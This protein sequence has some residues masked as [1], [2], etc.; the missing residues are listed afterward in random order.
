MKKAAAALVVLGIVLVLLEGLSW[1]ALRLRPTGNPLALPAAEAALHFYQPSDGWL[2]YR[3]KPNH[4]QRFRSDE[5]DTDIR[6]NSFGFRE[7]AE[8][9]GPVDI[10]VV[11]DTFA[12]GHGVE[13]GER[14]SDLLR[15]ARA[16]G[17]VWSF[18]LANGYAPPHYL[19][20]LRNNLQF[21]PQRLVIELFPWND[22][23]LNMF[24]MAFERDSN[25]AVVA[26]RSTQARVRPD[27]FW[28]RRDLTEDREPWWRAQARE[29]NLGRV[30]LLAHSQPVTACGGPALRQNTFGRHTTGPRAFCHPAVRRF[31]RIRPVCRNKPRCDHRDNVAGAK[32][33]RRCC[34]LLHSDILHG[35]RLSLFL[36]NAG[37][38]YRRGL[39]ALSRGQ[40]ARRG[41]ARLGSSPLSMAD[42]PGCRVPSPRSL[43]HAPLF[44]EGWP[45]DRSGPSCSGGSAVAASSAAGFRST[46]PTGMSGRLNRRSSPGPARG[47]APQSRPPRGRSSACR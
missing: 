42:R 23:S 17:N 37:W 35:W 45:V 21:V 46:P 11:G 36:R 7:N 12:F 6:T 24:D 34:D 5:F 31:W 41:F 22:L 8:P 43:R 33:W 9:A 38:L 39:R 10:G 3:I 29:F 32:P 47:R 30:V 18:A 44:R 14:H 26:I 27:G 20:F 1:L 16:G 13:V 4:A 28:S 19:L 2:F 15:R 40:P 25:G